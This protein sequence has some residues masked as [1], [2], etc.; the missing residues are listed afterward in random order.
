MDYIGCLED[1]DT[2]SSA[3]RSLTFPVAYKLGRQATL[4]LRN[5]R[6][7]DKFNN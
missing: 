2:F 5:L 1:A 3:Y 4:Q 7:F 6:F